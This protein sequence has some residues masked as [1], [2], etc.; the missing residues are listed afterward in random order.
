MD[1]MDAM[2]NA[3]RNFFLPTE[4]NEM[5]PLVLGREAFFVL[6]AIAAALIVTPAYLRVKN[7]ADLANPTLANFDAATVIDL[8]NQSRAA[9]GM[10]LLAPN[11]E[12]DLAAEEK[13]Q[14]MFANQYFAHFSPTGVSPWNFFARAGYSYIAAGE[15][16]AID[17][18]DAQDT[19]DAFMNSPT[20]R[21]NI[22]SPLYTQMGAAVESG[23]F[24]GRSTII[25]AQYFGAPKVAI[26]PIAA[27]APK[28][29][30]VTAV[31]PAPTT[32]SVKTASVPQAV[33]SSALVV[34]A[35]KSTS[36]PA[37]LGTETQSGPSAPPSIPAVPESAPAVSSAASAPVPAPST[38]SWLRSVVVTPQNGIKLV[39]IAAFFL[40]LLALSFV[41]MRSAAVPN[42]VL[43][44]ILLLL[45]F[46]YVIAFGAG[47]ISTAKIDPGSAAIVIT[48]QQ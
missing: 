44:S 3:I 42:V 7:I 21:D 16:L 25:V 18:P 13:V 17:F 32:V 35:Q 12:L 40:I 27:T 41:V 19:E 4:Q 30:A 8:A 26:A 36:S 10:P 5:L 20:H 47:A 29:T 6:L 46:G 9:N 33:A 48:Y 34:I 2:T 24:E 43:R 37:L 38:A 14:D 15:N 11:S 45:F 28:A 31:A 23:T 1:R 22:L 39:S